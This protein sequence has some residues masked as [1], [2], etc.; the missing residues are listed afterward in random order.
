MQTKSVR[1]GRIAIKLLVFLLPVIVILL[2]VM[3]V[4]SYRATKTAMLEATN[5][6][7]E[8]ESNYN[9]QIIETWQESIIAMCD[10]IEVSLER[11]P[12]ESDEEELDYLRSI[13]AAFVEKIPYGVYEGNAEGVYLDGSDWVPDDDYVVAERGW[14]KEGMTHEH[15]E[16][17]EAYVDAQTG[18]ATVSVSASID[19]ADKPG[20]VAS[21]DVYLDEITDAIANIK[22]MNS[23][24]GF[25]LLVDPNNQCIL[26][27]Q[28]ASKNGKY[29]ID[30]DMDSFYKELSTL[31]GTKSYEAKKLKKDG[32]NYF[33]SLH[34]ISK[35]GWVLVTCASE[36]EVL[37]E[38]SDLRV[39]YTVFTLIFIIITALVLTFVVGKTISPIKGLTNDIGR[40]AQGDLTVD[41]KSTGND[42][43]AT[44]SGALTEY[45]GSMQGI[46]RNIT[47]ISEEL[48]EN[49]EISKNTSRE[50]RENSET[51]ANAMDVM[52]ESIAQFV[53]AV[54]D[55][56]ENATTLAQVVDDT[57]KEGDFASRNMHG[58]VEITNRG[59]E[60][61]QTVQNNMSQIL[62]EIR[63]LEE[64][65][66]HV[67]EATEEINDIVTLIAEIASQTNLLSLNA[68]IEA[69]R[70]G[71]NGRGF[72]VVAS[73]IGKLAE[74]SA[75]SARQIGDIISKVND[76]VKDTVTKTQNN[77][78]RV[79][80]N[81]CAVDK[82]CDTFKEILGNVTQTN[83]IM[84]RMMLEIGKVND[85]ASNMAA[86]SEEQAASAEQISHSIEDLN[87]RAEDVAQDSQQVEACADVL[88]KS[89]VLLS[90]NMKKFTL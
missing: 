44:M 70:A 20:L 86:I 40:L 84:D 57:T 24:T 77:V 63:D 38:L 34:P 55:I 19:R 22:V 73:E 45:I 3:M 69:A 41:I 16:F 50:L 42:E 31:V 33:V 30:A 6:Q 46:I 75:Q 68:S 7:M 49:S 85:V 83:E 1:K 18:D 37:S 67:G 52:R 28:D 26:A 54:T 39:L 80:E 81:S 14:Y 82:A 53:L 23:K 29:L 78:E 79:E 36:K 51:Q 58:T 71:E 62:T 17:G 48:D 8:A 21:V 72:A 9:A 47:K 10:P 15:F 11:I 65:V 43:I 60:D 88:A 12:F 32:G 64:A 27:H 5:T 87:E 2:V 74:V 25:A 66:N 59:H 4:L 89:A 61:M 90:D 13:T 35:T 56:A 76:L